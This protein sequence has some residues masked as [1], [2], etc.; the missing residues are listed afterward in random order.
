MRKCRIACTLNNSKK[1]T[2]H[3]AKRLYQI[4]PIRVYSLSGSD[5]SPIATN[6]Y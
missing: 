2:E 6:F 3:L 1:C 4:K 5:I